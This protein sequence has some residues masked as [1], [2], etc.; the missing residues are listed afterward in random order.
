MERGETCGVDEESKE[1]GKEGYTLV[2]SGRLWE[3]IEAHAWKGSVIVDSL[4][5]VKYGWMFAPEEYSL[6]SSL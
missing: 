4:G 3:G 6:A 1:K 2:I 5:I